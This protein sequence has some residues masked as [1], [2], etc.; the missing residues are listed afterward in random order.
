[1]LN[2]SIGIILNILLN[3][4]NMKIKIDYDDSPN[5][6]MDKINSLL[7]QHGLQITYD[8]EEFEDYDCVEC[9]ITKIV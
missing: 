3:Q 1:M 5:N 8:K 2:I 6:V 4:N 7:K 9:E